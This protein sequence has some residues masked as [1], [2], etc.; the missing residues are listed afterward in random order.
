VAAVG[1]GRTYV[2]PVFVWLIWIYEVI[3]TVEAAIRFVVLLAADV[4][5][6]KLLA[7]LNLFCTIRSHVTDV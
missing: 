2:A 4:G 5:S 1:F 6:C 7:V 3:S